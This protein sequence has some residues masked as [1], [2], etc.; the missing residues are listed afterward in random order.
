MQEYKHKKVMWHDFSK[1]SLSNWNQRYL[2]FSMPE[3]EFKTL[4]VKVINDFME[5]ISKKMN[6]DKKKVKEKYNRYKW[7]KEK[8]ERLC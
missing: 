4:G 3:V 1:S 5:E 2:M 8:H 7:N 6:E